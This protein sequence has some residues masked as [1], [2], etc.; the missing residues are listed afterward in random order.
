MKKIVYLFLFIGIVTQAQEKYSTKNGSIMFE[1][2]V[3]SFEE[4]K[5]KNEQVSAILNVET[6]EFASLA[7]INGFRF[8]VALMEEHFN[9][10]YMESSQ[11]PKAIVKGTL[12]NFSLSEV[13]SEKKSFKLKGT[14]TMHGVTKPIETPVGISKSGDTLKLETD[15]VLQPADFNIEIPKIVSNKIAD[16]VNVTAQ[17]SLLK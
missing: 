11:F 15:F 16:K 13:S 10:N 17:Y 2:S 5:A 8:K 14:I 7:L 3:P 1:A 6:G 9:E 4:V 12:E